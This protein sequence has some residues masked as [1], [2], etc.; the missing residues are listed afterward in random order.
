[1]NV[2]DCEVPGCN[3][4]SMGVVV[5]RFSSFPKVNNLNMESI[6]LLQETY[7]SQGLQQC[8]TSHEGRFYMCG[9]RQ[10]S[11]SSGSMVQVSPFTSHHY[12]DENKI[13]TS[14]I[15]FCQPMLKDLSRQALDVRDSSGQVQCGMLKAALWRSKQEEITSTSISPHIIFTM[16]K[17]N[18]IISRDVHFSN[19]EH[20]D[21]DDCGSHH[22]QTVFDYVQQCKNQTLKDYMKKIDQMYPARTRNEKSGEKLFHVPSTCV[23]I[24]VNPNPLFK[25]I[26]YVTFSEAGCCCNLESDMPSSVTSTF[27]GGIVGHVTSRTYWINQVDNQIT[28]IC[29]DKCTLLAWG[30]T[31]SKKKNNKRKR[32]T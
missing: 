6:N 32:N 22:A 28:L 24:H 3:A 27:L 26:Q 18:K 15:N 2:N 14:L 23:W 10:S 25:S 30:N 8:R 1:M 7:H 12:F 5:A 16:W 19:C 20:V 17:N 4:N 11:T 21:S 31:P 29:P 9:L 13:N